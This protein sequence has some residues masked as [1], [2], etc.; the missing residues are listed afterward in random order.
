MAIVT[1]FHHGV[2]VITGSASGIGAALARVAVD[3]GMKVVLV[4]VD[5]EAVTR[6]A[7]ELT[8]GG[9]A[10]HAEVADVGDLAA[11][12]D[13]ADRTYH[14]FGTV[15]LLVN[16]AGVEAHGLTWELTAEQWR[17]IVAVNLTGVFNGIHV[18]VPRMLQA[19]QQSSK[20]F[21][22]VNTASV[23]ALRVRPYTA[24]YAATKHA[25][26][27]L[28]DSV[29]L[30]LADVTDQV[31]LSTALPAAV[32]TAVFTN[33]MTAP[34]SEAGEI[35]RATLA[36]LVDRSGIDPLDAA[37]IIL[38]GAALGIPHIHTDPEFSQ[39]CIRSR[40]AELIHLAQLT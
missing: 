3:R 9:G 18:F 38:D 27:A 30:E 16:N 19:A 31:V 15:D 11:V 35:D 6:V 1:D 25:V 32:R 33:A 20:R 8:E 12:Q 22:V 13:I 39:S 37:R 5:A 10:V 17:R 21:H 28:T 7:H 29:R 40:S 26:L 4:D 23:A 34:G 36:D 24:T 2:A 14:S